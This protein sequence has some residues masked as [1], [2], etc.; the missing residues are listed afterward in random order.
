MLSCAFSFEVGAQSQTQL[1][2]QNA[3]PTSSASGE[4]IMVG[5]F[6]FSPTIQINWQHRDNIFFTPDNEVADQVY[7]A[8]ATLLFEVPINESFI[9]FS[10]SP[11]YT[12]YRKYDLEDK[13]SHFFDVGGSFV[14]ANGLVLNANYEY[15]IGNLQTRQI[16]EGGELYY[17][18]PNFTKQ[19]AR[20][21]AQYWFT[22]RD[23]VFV[24][25][26]WT[27]LENSDPTLFYDYD[28]VSAGFG[29]LHQLG[30][31]T[32]M[33]VRYA[34]SDFDAHD[35][36]FTLNGFRDSTSDEVTVGLQGN[37]SPVV[38]TGI[39]LGYLEVNYDVQPGDPPVS[40]FSGFVVNGFIDWALGHG[41]TVRLELLRSPYPSN[42]ADNANYLA[43]GGALQY[44]LDRGSFYG[45]VNGAYQNNDYE[46]PDPVSGEIRSDDILTLGLGLGYRFTQHLSLWGSYVYEDRD[47]LYPY[48]YT[49]N[50]Y[51]LGLVF[52]F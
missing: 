16:D 34:R 31:N 21:S 52:G 46:L 7:Q 8:G 25:G 49:T 15:I 20:V 6:L 36:E 24:E 42:Y 1:S 2:T 10:Y 19:N 32:T 12:D 41:S 37:V 18:D 28:R 45:S 30:P 23:G 39:R 27:D 26:A 11:L 29:W 33:N 35:T 51:T 47:S 22:H 14:F 13:W 50:I 44:F 5:P 40:D 48:S 38:S 17:G 43:T 9:H 3:R 4:P